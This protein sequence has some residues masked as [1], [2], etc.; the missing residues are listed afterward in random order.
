[1]LTQA[2]SRARH[3][4]MLIGRTAVL[5]SAVLSVLAAVVLIVL[6]VWLWPSMADRKADW[7]AQIQSRFA[8]QGL[9][10]TVGELVADWET[11][12]RPRLQVERLA[13]ENATGERVLT[14][15]SLQAVLGPRSLASIW[16]WQPIFSEVR[17]QAPQLY[18]ER[19]ADGAM[20]VAGFPIGLGKA[21]AALFTWLLRQGR[22]RIDGGELTWRDALRDR[23]ARLRD[24]TFAMSNLSVKHAWALRATPPS[25]LGEGFV[26]QGDFRHALFGPAADVQKWVGEAFIQF[27]RVN[28]SELFQFVHLPEAAPLKVN[29]GQG[30]MRAWIKLDAGV[31]EDLTVDLDL[32]NASLQWGTPRRPMTLQRLTGRVQTTLSDQRQEVSLSNISLE[33]AQLKTIAKIPAARLSVV[34]DPGLNTAATTVSAK[35]ID[36]AAVMWLMEHLPLSEDLRGELYAFQPRGSMTDMRLSWQEESDQAKGFSIES[37]FDHLSLAAGA[38]RPGFSNLSGRIK[39]SQEGGEITLASRAL[40][41][42]FPGV[43]ASQSLPFDRLDAQ[44]SWSAKHLLSTTEK[45]TVPEL[46]LSVRKFAV[47]NPDLALEVL[48]SY[49]WQSGGLGVA[50]LTG[51]V[52]RAEFK[53]IVDYVPLIVSKNTRAWLRDGL[54]AAKTTSATFE[55]RG[56]LERFPFREPTDGRFIVNAQTEGASLRPAPGWPV[57]NNIQ[58]SVVFD[59]H[60]FRTQASGARLNDLSIGTIDARIDDLEAQRPLLRVDGAISGDFQKI[61]DT[62]NQSP[63]KAMLRDA[64]ADMRA[65]GQATL[66]LGLRLDLDDSDRSQVSGRLSSTRSLFRYAAALPEIS[67]NTAEVAF[68][69]SGISQLDLQGQSLGGPVRVSA[70]PADKASTSPAALN[71]LIEGQ[72]S[73]SGL[74]QWAEEIL[75]LSIKNSFSGS[76][77]YSAALDVRESST[78]AVIRSSL[79]GLGSELF[80]ALKKRPRDDWGLRID[81]QHQ[82]PRPG[83]ASVGTQTWVISSNQ[84]RLNA[85]IQRSLSARKETVIDVDSKQLAG[86]F[87]WTPAAAQAKGAKGPRPA[88]LLQAQLSR[89]YLDK[90]DPSAESGPEST[91]DALAQDWP[92]VDLAVDDFRIG[93]RVWGRLE[94][95]ASPVYATR[96]WEILRFSLL[97]PDAELTGQ[98]QWAML[99]QGRG[100]RRSR[101]SLDVALKMKSGGALL[102]RSG[103]PK[104]V[105]DTPG[106]IEGKLHWP[107]SPLDFSGASLNGNLSLNLQQGQFLKAEPG[108]ARLVSVLN[109][110]SLPRRIKLDFRDI[111]SD[112]FT[113]EQIRGDL[114]FLNG[115]ASTQNLRI[116]GVQ[117]SVMLEGSAD[118]KQETQDLR[119]LVLPEV[120][121]GL[122]SLGYAA[123]VNP[124]IGLGAFVAQYILRNPMREL[125]SYEYRVTGSWDD[126]VVESVR[127]EMRSDSPVMKAK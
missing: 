8:E 124:A 11:W 49:R 4:L 6:H 63:V 102:A 100:P 47:S 22:I 123:L 94:A 91:S 110:Q 73:A 85:K 71:L 72:A 16:H 109:L 93:D 50:D 9:T 62:A 97:N 90:H 61:I 101:T 37:G 105:R 112:G 3:F 1:M 25:S 57:M 75:G 21:D 66:V 19:H 120:N 18:A 74:E 42:S 103:Y 7:F 118:I 48:G 2:P 28:L 125:L 86:Q 89:L 106:R 51:K 38:R 34:R 82:E 87:R 77:R 64:S 58:A 31:L 104:L 35:T 78:R 81:F 98:G 127:R 111:F 15:A 108:L 96:S 65:K 20:K 26:L 76:A 83:T 69:E 117:A 40:S 36:L 39:A 116:I 68:T 29:A 45:S 46:E 119:V 17:F 84:Q 122:A 32:S 113:Y 95:Q 44:M 99:P 121:A 27:D 24:I 54:V 60:Q 70:K 14:I 55:L 92:T 52:T 79:E 115:Q 10:M 13:V 88:G 5:S 33:S 67:I 23:S 41:L 30:A 126:P 43:F 12:Y 56:P 80:G 107:G 53:K 114:Q 59:R